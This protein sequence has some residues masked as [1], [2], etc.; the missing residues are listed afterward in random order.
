[1]FCYFFS[2]VFFR[3]FGAPAVKV[4]SKSHNSEPTAE[5]SPT[6][7]PESPES[8]SVLVSLE[9][10]EKVQE[11]NCNRI[12]VEELIEDSSKTSKAPLSPVLTNTLPAKPKKVFQWN[13]LS[14]MFAYTK[15]KDIII[16]SSPATMS[17]FKLVTQKKLDSASKENSLISSQNSVT[18]E[19]SSQTSCLSE[20]SL[21]SDVGSV[22]NESF[23]MTP[24]SVPSTPEMTSVLTPDETTTAVTKGTKMLTPL[25]SPTV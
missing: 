23:N 19:L 3:Y 4:S 11:K 25:T 2:S 7:K 9:N 15:D 22:D 16:E 10:S 24:L 21:L 12:E 6:Q 14:E 8:Q 17:D 20:V 18:E 13:Q 1:M 5:K